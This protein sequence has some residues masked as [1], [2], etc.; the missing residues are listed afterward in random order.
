M[1]NIFR[2]HRCQNWGSWH[3]IDRDAPGKIWWVEQTKLNVVPHLMQE[4]RPSGPTHCLAHITRLGGSHSPTST[5]KAIRDAS[6]A[7]WRGWG[8]PAVTRPPDSVLE[9]ELKPELIPISK[10]AAHRWYNHD[11]YSSLSLLSARLAVTF[12]LASPCFGRHQIILVGDRGAFG[13][14]SLLKGVTWQ[15]QG[16]EVE[17]A[18]SWSHGQQL[19]HYTG[20]SQHHT[21]TMTYFHSPALKTSTTVSSTSH[22]QISVCT[23]K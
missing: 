22:V 13:M 11:L 16:W 12:P 5:T 21:I 20:K 8:R 4:L 17:R 19:F 15:Q 3:G 9:R 1:M 2:C 6:R 14:K 23:C 18:T 10:H 7:S